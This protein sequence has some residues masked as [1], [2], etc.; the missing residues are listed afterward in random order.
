MRPLVLLVEDDEELINTVCSA[1]TE[2][3]YDFEVYHRSLETLLAFYQRPSRFDLVILDEDMGDM[4]GSVLAG[5]LLHFSRAPIV[6]LYRQGDL[7]AEAKGRFGG[8]RGFL[9]KPISIGGLIATAE[10]GLGSKAYR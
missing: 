3:G 8:V 10:E 4:P 2:H 6:L 1:L 7:E 9:S 5:R